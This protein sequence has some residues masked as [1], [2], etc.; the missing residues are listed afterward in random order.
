MTIEFPSRSPDTKK[1]LFERLRMILRHGP[2]EMPKT[3]RYGGHGGPGCLLEDLFGL[4]VGSQD[5]ADSVGWEIKYYTKKTNLITLFH[6]EAMPEGIMR[7]I[8]R[9]WGWRDDKGRMSF[10]HTIAGKSDRYKV[11]V[12]GEWIRVL[13]LKGNGVVP[14]WT[15]NDLLNIIGSKLRRLM[16]VKGEKK[17]Q[18]ITFKLADCYENLYMDSFVEE[19]ERG[20]VCIDFDA[21]E[22]KADSPGLRNHGTKF[23][24]HPDNVHRLY[25]KKER[26]VV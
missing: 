25:M 12:D 5:I 11:E 10:R 6:R 24:V 14:Y 20:T 18:T 26:F 21:R 7:I 17:G 8:V 13:P 3:S 19:L 4:K 22:M 2:Y 23:R 15:R 1:Q 9:K 16:L